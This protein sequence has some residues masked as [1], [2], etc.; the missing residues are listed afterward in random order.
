[1]TVL[2]KRK[3]EVI[4]G[5]LGSTGKSFDNLRVSFEIEMDDRKET[6]SAKISIYNL[7]QDSLG[8][9]DQENVSVI[10]KLG[11][12]NNNDLSI[13]FIG[14][15]VVYETTLD[16]AD[17]ITKITLK[18][19]YI[20]LTQRFLSLSFPSN[21][22]TRQI[23][24]KIIN[25]LNLTKD[26]YSALP[27][28]VYKQGF[29]FGGAPSK[30]LTIVLDRI[31]YEW[32]IINNVL[33]ITKPNQSNKTTVAQ[34]L[35]LKTGLKESPKRFKEQQAN[36]RSRTDAI[37]NGWRILC[38]IIP[39]IVPKNLI[40]VESET[41]NGIF[42]VRSVKMQGDTEGDDWDCEIKATQQ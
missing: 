20:P 33:T 11:Y 38:S 19:G 14:D 37:V 7:A 9:L 41:A 6:N 26:N 36:T 31:G 12:G 10:L 5:T 16:D 18:D 21:V 1:M 28:Y 27:N 24:T 40:K 23:I 22:T 8:L 35:S 34:F 13:V 25:D 32:A 17:T 39:S 2:Y 30:A 42:I 3:A 15:V 29:S 4:I